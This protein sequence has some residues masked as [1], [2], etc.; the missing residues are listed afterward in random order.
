M[1]LQRKKCNQWKEILRWKNDLES[2]GSIHV[3]TK[4]KYSPEY[5]PGNLLELEAN[6]LLEPELC[7]VVISQKANKRITSSPVPE[8]KYSLAEIGQIC[9]ET[10]QSYSGLSIQLLDLLS[11]AIG[12]STYLYKHRKKRVHK[13]KQKYCRIQPISLNGPHCNLRSAVLSWWHLS[14]S[15]QDLKK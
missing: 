3:N 11:P 9:G 1:S 12:F 7:N 6:H 14:F 2:T 15:T 5:S 4:R 13:E 10:L 8:A